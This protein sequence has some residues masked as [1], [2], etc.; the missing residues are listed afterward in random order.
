MGRLTEVFKDVLSMD[1]EKEYITVRQLNRTI[2]LILIYGFVLSAVLSF[3]FG[4]IFRSGRFT[5]LFAAWCIISIATELVFQCTSKLGIQF[6][7]FQILAL[8]LAPAVHAFI[9]MGVMG[10]Q[11]CSWFVFLHRCQE[12]IFDPH[13][14][15]VIGEYICGQGLSICEFE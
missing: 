12:D 9:G 14:N 2:G 5:W 15:L 8:L 4:N 11:V 7:L 13:C 10:L 3:F 6:V 1:T